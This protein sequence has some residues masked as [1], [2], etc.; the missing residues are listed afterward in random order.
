MMR[1][2]DPQH[3]QTVQ[4]QFLNVFGGRFQNRL[5]LVVMLQTVGVFAVASVDGTTGRLDIGGF[6]MF[7]TQSAQNGRGVERA[8]ADLHVV[9]LQDNAPLF[10]PIGVKFQNQR[11]EIASCFFYHL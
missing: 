4:I 5:I 8:G 3:F 7:G 2:I 1:R 10:R 9:G 11:L 6:P